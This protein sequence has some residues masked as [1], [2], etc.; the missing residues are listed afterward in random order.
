MTERIG[1]GAG[2]ALALP[3]ATGI[4]HDYL[5]WDG[6]RGEERRGES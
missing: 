4:A 2:V 3:L 1:V 6:Q 5:W